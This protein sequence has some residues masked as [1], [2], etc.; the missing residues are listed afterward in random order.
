MGMKGENALQRMKYHPILKPTAVNNTTVDGAAIS[1][2]WRDGRRIVFGIRA[3]IPGSSDLSCKVIGKK[4]S[5][6]NWEAVLDKAGAEILFPGAKLEDATDG[7]TVGLLGELDLSRFKAE[8]YSDISLRFI[9]GA[10]TAVVA[11][12]WGLVTDLY[13]VPSGQADEFSAVELQ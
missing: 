8:T 13:S 1:E 11:S 4:R 10:A 3:D 12:A 7:E 2:P 6:G 9:N 5:D